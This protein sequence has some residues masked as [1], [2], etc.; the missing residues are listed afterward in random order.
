MIIHIIA[1]YKK[2]Y[3]ITKFDL[4]LYNYALKFD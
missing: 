1:G 3:V 4:D 2:D